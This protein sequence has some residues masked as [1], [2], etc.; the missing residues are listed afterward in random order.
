MGDDPV[1]DVLGDPP[2]PHG[3]VLVGARRQL[4]PQPL[5]QTGDGVH[6]LQV[7]SGKGGARGHDRTEDHGRPP[8]GRRI[9]IVHESVQGDR[10]QRPELIG[11][12]KITQHQQKALRE[13]VPVQ[14][15]ALGDRPGRVLH[16]IGVDHVARRLR[17]RHDPVPRQLP[18]QHQLPGPGVVRRRHLS[19]QPLRPPGRGVERGGEVLDGGLGLPAAQPRRHLRYGRVVPPYIG[20]LPCGPLLVL[21]PVGGRLPRRTRR[22]ALHPGQGTHPEGRGPAPRRQQPLQRLDLRVEFLGTPPRLRL[23]QLP[24]HP[25]LLAIAG[26]EIPLLGTLLPVQ[27][28]LVTGLRFLSTLLLALRFSP[29]ADP[30][31]GATAHALQALPTSAPAYPHPAP[32]PITSSDGPTL[33]GNQP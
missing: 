19:R 25:P 29:G 10:L 21:L 18:V 27:F 6:L 4:P 5:H 12:E 17:L 31:I 22:H 1:A 3:R 26:P 33:V 15:A 11:R 14:G 32:G 28:P 8:A 2:G 30:P 20:Q 23:P 9:V 7:Q 13:D 24:V 16:L